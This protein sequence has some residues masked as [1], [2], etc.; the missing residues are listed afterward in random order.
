MRQHGARSSTSLCWSARGHAI[1][2]V[3]RL[4]Q[5]L[6]DRLVHHPLPVNR[7]LA[8]KRGGD[9]VDAGA[10]RT[11]AGD[12]GGLGSGDGGGAGALPPRSAHAP[13]VAPVAALVLHAHVLR[14]Q[15]SRNLSSRALVERSLRRADSAALAFSDMVAISPSLTCPAPPGAAL[16]VATARRGAARR[17]WVRGADAEAQALTRPPPQDARHSAAAT[18]RSELSA[19]AM[20]G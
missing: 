5:F 16:R 15:R 3:N 12:G 17:A 7:A 1:H 11:Q 8:L 13:H 19:E 20:T 18:H 4:L 2:R 9:H 14:L 10:R 6:P